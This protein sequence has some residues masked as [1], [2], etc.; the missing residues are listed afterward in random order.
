MKVKLRLF[1]LLRASFLTTMANSKVVYSAAAK[2]IPPE[3]S[4]EIVSYADKVKLPPRP[5]KRSENEMRKRE[6]SF[7]APIKRSTGFRQ[8]PA[9]PHRRIDETYLQNFIQLKFEQKAIDHY[10]YMKGTAVAGLAGSRC[11]DYMPAKHKVP[12]ISRRQD[13]KN[14]ITESLANTM[15]S[16]VDFDSLHTEKQTE[17][18]SPVLPHPT[19]THG[20]TYNNLT[21]PLSEITLDIS[22]DEDFTAEEWLQLKQQSTESEG[23]VPYEDPPPTLMENIQE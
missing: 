12:P 6:L 9:L 15:K 13:P 16:S 20:Q 1:I 23:S 10:K 11:T 14:Y 8:L 17:N 4:G 18:R 21:D 2:T 5:M 3:I 7:S 19:P 22:D